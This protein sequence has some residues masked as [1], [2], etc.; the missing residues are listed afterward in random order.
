M[1]A[2]AYLTPEKMGNVWELYRENNEL[3]KQLLAVWQAN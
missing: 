2:S 3:L 1:S